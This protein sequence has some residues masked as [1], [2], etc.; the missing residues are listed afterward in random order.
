ML[1]V[2]PKGKVVSDLFKLI[3]KEQTTHDIL[4]LETLFS[5]IQTQLTRISN[6]TYVFIAQKKRRQTG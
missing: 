5:N 1:K 4:L 3:K 2:K 6:F